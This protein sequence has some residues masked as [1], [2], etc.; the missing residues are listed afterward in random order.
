M[1]SIKSSSFTRNTIPKYNS[2]KKIK[3][4]IYL[5][6]DVQYRFLFGGASLIRT[7]PHYTD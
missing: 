1:H 7:A 4:T 2:L 5:L 6:N 3:L